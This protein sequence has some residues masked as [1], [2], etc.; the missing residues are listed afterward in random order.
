MKNAWC[1]PFF[2]SSSINLVVFILL[3]AMVAGCQKTPRP[4]AEPP[5]RLVVFAAASTADALDAVL[6][7]YRRERPNLD[8]RTSYGASSTLAQQIA[9]GAD[10]QLFLSADEDWVEFLVEQN[11]VSEFDILLSNSLVLIASSGSQIKIDS[12]AGLTSDKIA[13]ISLADPEHVPAGKYARKALEAV[14]VWDQV[15]GKVVSGNDVRRALAFVETRAADMGIVYATDALISK[16]VEV[17]A[18]IPLALSG[19][20]DYPIAVIRHS[21]SAGAERPRSVEA[22]RLFEYLHSPSA[23]AEFERFGFTSGESATVAEQRPDLE[24]Q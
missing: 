10:A 6:K 9:H 14:G 7:A 1:E 16:R 19:T 24:L 8:I 11:R 13:K 17:V 3:W 21:D 4:G 22:Q 18:H 12:L 5:E 15:K 23:M 20:I 2:R